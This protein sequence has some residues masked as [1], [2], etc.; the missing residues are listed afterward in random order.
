M[1]NLEC[2]VAEPG[3]YLVRNL[4][5]KKV[6]IGQ[7]INIKKRFLSHHLYDFKNESNSSYNS[8]FYQAL[9]K[10]GLDN[11]ELQIVVICPVSELNDREKYYIEYY[12]SFYNGYNSTIGGQSMPDNLFSEETKQKRLDTLE[13]TS[14]L[15]S[16][17]HPR[18]KLKNDEVIKIRQRYIDGESCEEIHKDYVQYALATFEKIVFGTSYISVG[19][20]PQKDQIRRTNAKFTK[21]QIIDIRNAYANNEASPKELSEKYQVSISTITSI[22]KRRTYCRIE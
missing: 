17:N 21:E 11:F 7:S 18:A 15:K 4:I 12:D 1:K 8:K 5:N 20:I 9:R 19:N 14:A 3:I 13:K 10:H 6:Y 16:E 2:L 22:I